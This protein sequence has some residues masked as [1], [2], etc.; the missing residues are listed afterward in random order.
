[1]IWANMAINWQFKVGQKAGKGE[2]CSLLDLEHFLLIN[3]F[4]KTN[5]EN[6]S[7]G[8]LPESLRRGPYAVVE[9]ADRAKPLYYGGGVKYHQDWLLFWTLVLLK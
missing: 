1:M 6:L 4:V 8:V 7:R 5:F 9:Q 3:F 2:Q